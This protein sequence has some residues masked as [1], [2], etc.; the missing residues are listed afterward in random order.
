M[1]VIEKWINLAL[2]KLKSWLE[3][4][5]LTKELVLRNW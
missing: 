2:L 4:F 5:D 3:K 1:F